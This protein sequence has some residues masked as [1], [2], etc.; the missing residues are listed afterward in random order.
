M[1]TAKYFHKTSIAR[2][3]PVCRI[4]TQEDPMKWIPLNPKTSAFILGGKLTGTL[5]KNT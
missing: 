4:G 2:S 1:Q 5:I 3:F